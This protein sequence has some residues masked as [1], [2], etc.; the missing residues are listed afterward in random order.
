MVIA[1][2][3][4]LA[5]HFR[6]EERLSEVA[7]E[8][9]EPLNKQEKKLELDLGYYI[10]LAGL[11]LER[12][13]ISTRD[14]FNIVLEHIVNPKESGEKRARRYPV[15]LQ[16][17]LMQS[18]AAYAT[19]GNGSLAAFLFECGFDVWLGNNRCGFSP[20]HI[21]YS[22]YNVHMWQWGIRE[23]G[24]LDIPCMIDFILNQ[25]GSNTHK[26][27]LV[28]HSQGTTQTFYALAKGVAPEMG[29]KLSSFSALAPAVY[30]GPLLDR[31]F[32][33]F[34]R[35][36]PRPVY[37]AF[38]G[39]H[40]FIGLMNGF[41][42]IMPKT[43]YTFFGYIMFNYL[44]GWDDRLWNR[45]YRNRQFLFSPV[46]VS[47]DL[48]FWW[49][50]KGGFACHGCIF[51]ESV[52]QWFDHSTFPPLAL[53]VPGRDNLVS[54]YPLVNRLKSYERLE[55]P[56][57]VVDIPGYSHLD[58]LWAHDVIDKVGRPLAKFIWSQVEDKHNWDTTISL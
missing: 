33:K 4:A 7:P 56:V 9:Y 57:E 21:L 37:H 54:P 31:W 3:K 10:R 51:D 24:S 19:S 32:L 45:H 8:L 28:G 23:M 43:W 39:H 14:G 13:V 16:H 5:R 25:H 15:L 1:L 48:M 52:D 53:F 20:S 18:S 38:F 27:A 49:L 12:H 47:S 55:T 11:D 22:R 17:G 41:H 46:Y 44:L 2:F 36:L 30:T 58:V 26:V 34:V 50:G 29:N 42:A 40:S 6:G 35:S